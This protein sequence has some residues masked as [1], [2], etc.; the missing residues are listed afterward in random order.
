M[1]D[2][3]ENTRDRRPFPPAARVGPNLAAS[4][5]GMSLYGGSRHARWVVLV[6]LMFTGPTGGADTDDG[7][8]IRPAKDF[9]STRYSALS[10]INT[11]TVKN[12]RLAWSFSTGVTRGHEAAPLVVGAAM[13]V[14][15]PYPNILY[16]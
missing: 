8:W 3:I 12:L 4:D 9:A 13:Y 5:P 16:G 14:V 6:A 2:Q 1:F 7:Q 10:E 11:Q 15:T